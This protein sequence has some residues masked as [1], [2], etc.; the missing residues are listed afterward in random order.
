M[1]SAYLSSASYYG[2]YYVYHLNQPFK[3]RFLILHYENTSDYPHAI[4]FTNDV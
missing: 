1:I 3:S 2:E 4:Q